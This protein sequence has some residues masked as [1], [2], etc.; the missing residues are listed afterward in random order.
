MARYSRRSETL[1]EQ[2]DDLDKLQPALVAFSAASL[3]N[4]WNQPNKL[5][6]G[7]RLANNSSVLGIDIG[8]TATRASLLDESQPSQ[9]PD[10]IVRPY[11]FSYS[12]R[13]SDGQFPATALPFEVSKPP[14]A[15]LSYPNDGSVDEFSL[16]LCCY[17]KKLKAFEEKNNEKQIKLTLEHIPQLKRFWKKFKSCSDALMSRVED[18][19][20]AIFQHH[21]SIIRKQSERKAKDKSLRIRKLAVTIPPNWDKVLQDWYSKMFAVV[22]PEIDEKHISFVYESEA[23]CH[24]LLRLNNSTKRK[25][26]IQ[27]ILIADFGG[28]TLVSRKS[29]GRLFRS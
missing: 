13:G 14:V 16:K 10:M 1:L 27:R 23:I 12:E 11:R 7:I 17:V 2:T 15:C 5:L 18:H 3:H 26:A 19:I 24:Y 21:L 20:E 28:H 22:W 29:S 4:S 6:L 8:T 25:E 9:Q